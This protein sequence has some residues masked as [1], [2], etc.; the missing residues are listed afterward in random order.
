[1]ASE[2]I[3]LRIN[4]KDR[5]SKS[6]SKV[7]QNIS[8]TGQ[9]SRSMT[10]SMAGGFGLVKT[11]VIGLSAVVTG[12]LAASLIRINTQFEDLQAQFNPLLGGMDAAKKRM[13]ELEQFAMVTP[14]QIEQVAAGSKVLQ[15]FG[16]DAMST[17]ESLRLVGDAAAFA[18]IQYK[19]MANWIGRAYTGLKSGKP[20]GEA[21]QRLQELAVL[22]GDARVK[23][24]ELQKAGKRK[25][26]WK[27]LENSLRETSGTMK[28]MQGTLSGVWS[29]L[30]GRGKKAI[31]DMTSGSMDKLKNVIKNISNSLA[32]L[33]KSGFFEKLGNK[34][35]SFFEKIMGLKVVV[36][37]IGRG[38]IQ[39]SKGVY[40]F[41]KNFTLAGDIIS[42]SI[43]S[44]KT[45]VNKIN[46]LNSVIEKHRNNMQLQKR[47]YQQTYEQAKKVAALQ[48]ELSKATSSGKDRLASNMR[49]KLQKGEDR[50]DELKK[51][52]EKQFNVSL[53]DLT[54]KKGLSE[55]KNRLSSI[56]DQIKN[57][58]DESKKAAGNLD[59]LSK[60]IEDAQRKRNEGKDEDK[61][62]DKEQKMLYFPGYKELPSITEVPRIAAQAEEKATNR[63]E[64]ARKERFQAAK[65]FQNKMQQQNKTELQQL[66]SWYNKKKEMLRQHELDTTQL[67]KVYEER[68]NRI[69]QKMQRKSLRQKQQYMQATSSIF[70]N[71]S[72][73]FAAANQESKK[74]KQEERAMAIVQAEIQALL[75]STKAFASAPN[76]VIGGILAGTAFAA[77]Q[78]Q[79]S[80]MK[81]KRFANSGIVDEGNGFVGDRGVARV[82]DGEAVVNRND[83]MRFLREIKNPTNNNQEN[84]IT[85]YNYGNDNSESGSAV[86]EEIDRKLKEREFFYGN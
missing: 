12:K 63:I 42:S 5:A 14:Y 75:A 46:E 31:R 61:D 82:N 38:F 81:N 19:E 45:L 69:E 55:L 20:I 40:K 77:Q 6:L 76:P 83:Q 57:T 78:V 3:D 51:L 84:Q 64:Q 16:G 60:K 26:A 18:G 27:V 28:I 86:A 33:I 71:L 73:I 70:G 44:I 58:G 4:A 66:N 52:A 74:A 21:M 56:N 68:K 35:G 43:N 39:A 48:K 36:E 9:K 17:G 10:Q 29:T 47:S 22:S 23:I 15:A 2:R 67:T 72:T 8:Q 59:E 34:V 1:M 79:I 25:E 80:K 54:T 32:S 11:A 53:G 65:K 24:E 7:R 85:V 30:V 37:E 62:K 41:F 49:K 50:L 13:S